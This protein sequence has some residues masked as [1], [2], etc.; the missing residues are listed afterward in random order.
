MQKVDSVG[1]TR[2]PIKSSGTWHDGYQRIVGE[3]GLCFWLQHGQGG[4]RTQDTETRS[5]GVE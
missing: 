4:V 2:S 5:L 3:A 1:T